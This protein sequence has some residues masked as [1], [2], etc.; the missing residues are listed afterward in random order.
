MRTDTPNIIDLVEDI[1]KGKIQLPQFQREWIWDDEKICRLIASITLNYPIGAVMFLNCGNNSPFAYRSIEFAP[2]NNKPENLILDGQQ[3]LTSIYTVMYSDNPVTINKRNDKKIKCYFYI[4]LEK[5]ANPSCDRADAIFSVP[6]NRKIKKTRK[7]D[8]LDLSTPE[9]EF[10][11][12]MYPLCIIFDS[13]K[14]DEWEEN[15]KKY[16]AEDQRARDIFS[17]FK[18]EVINKISRYQIPVIELERDTELAAVCE[19]FKNVNSNNVKLDDF[20]LVT[21]IFAKADST[22]DLRSDWEKRSHKF[23]SKGILNEFKRT[24]FLRAC[25]LMAIYNSAGNSDYTAKRGEVINLQYSDYC[26]YADDLSQGFEEAR[27]LLQEEGIVS[28]NSLPYTSQLIPLA[29]ICAIIKD[30][31]S[32]V[33]RKKIKCWYWC[34]VFEENYSNAAN[35][36]KFLNDVKTVINWIEDK[37]IPPLVKDFKFDAVKLKEIRAGALCKA[38]VA[39]IVKNE[40]RDFLDGRLIKDLYRE[41][42]GEKISKVELHHIFP[43]DFCKKKYDESLWDSVI[44]KTPLSKATNDFAGNRRPSDYLEKMTVADKNE[45]FSKKKKSQKDKIEKLVNKSDLESYLNLHWINPEDLY[46]DDFENFMS[47]RTDFLLN[48]VKKV[49]EID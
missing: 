15:Y 22:F 8:E 20:D 1:H 14:N 13:E 45:N 36:T 3:R 25:K 31:I 9:K 4:N 17:A 34:G 38:V 28:R 46:N 18:K 41:E 19:I 26:K 12:K 40:C 5:F 11:N 10:E 24:D 47:N 49:T 30:K 42:A 21:A 48:A 29:V 2:T 32:D 23:F 33:V 43:K 44:N 16:Y 27:K 39:L 35:L 7:N 37:E 6:E